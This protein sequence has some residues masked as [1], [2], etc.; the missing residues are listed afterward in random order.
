[1]TKI[2]IKY[3]RHEKC[4]CIQFINIDIHK[5]NISIRF[6]DLGVFLPNNNVFYYNSIHNIIQN[7]VIFN[8]DPG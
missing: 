4:A 7:N 3:L 2:K 6:Q 8:Q 1:M 5:N